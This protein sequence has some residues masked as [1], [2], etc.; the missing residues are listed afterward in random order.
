VNDGTVVAVVL[1]RSPMTS[2]FGPIP[3]V[4]WVVF[5]ST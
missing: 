3:K 2:M 1:V 5:D 4:F